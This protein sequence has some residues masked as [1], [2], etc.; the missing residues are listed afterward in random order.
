MHVFEF[1]LLDDFELERVVG[2]GVLV[3]DDVGGREGGVFKELLVCSERLFELD[4]VC[5]QAIFEKAMEI[6]FS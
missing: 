6:M 2:S 5:V 4:C 1:L 3:H